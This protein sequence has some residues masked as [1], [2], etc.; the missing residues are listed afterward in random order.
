MRY[1]IADKSAVAQLGISLAGHRTNRNLVLLNEKEVMT[2][3]GIS[4]DTLEERAEKIGGTVYGHD[5]IVHELKQGGVEELTVNN[6][7]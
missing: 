4:G 3:A 1:I 6:E 7:K 5:A 2:A